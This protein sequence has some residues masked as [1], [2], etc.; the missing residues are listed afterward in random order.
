VSRFGWLAA[1]RASATNP[2]AVLTPP[3]G[4]GSETR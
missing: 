2:E 1:G 3:E 4:S